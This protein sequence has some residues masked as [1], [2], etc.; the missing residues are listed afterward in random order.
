MFMTTTV[1]KNLFTK[2]ATR[3]YPFQKVEPF[4]N[5][6]GELV[7][8]IEK[9]TMCTVCQLKCPSQCIKVDR[10]AKLWEVDPYACVYCGICVEACPAKCLSQ[11]GMYRAPAA[12]KTIVSLLQEPKPEPA[13]QS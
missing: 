9:C 8:D 5:Q 13:A 1:L 12:V 2:Y 10:K 11:K 3:L 4:A 6:K 7:N